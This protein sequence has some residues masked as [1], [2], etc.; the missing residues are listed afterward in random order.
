MHCAVA[1]CAGCIV[2]TENN[3]ILSTLLLYYK[4]VLIMSY[5]YNEATVVRDDISMMRFN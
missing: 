5:L 3:E 2:A 1:S 4:Y